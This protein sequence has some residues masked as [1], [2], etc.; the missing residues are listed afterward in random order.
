M[1][2]LPWAC[3]WQLSLGV[4]G[5]SDGNYFTLPQRSSGA[6][7]EVAGKEKWLSDCVTRLKSLQARCVCIFC[8][9][10]GGS[11]RKKSWNSLCQTEGVC[12][13][14][15]GALAPGLLWW[16]HVLLWLQGRVSVC[17]CQLSWTLLQPPWVIRAISWGRRHREST[18]NCGLGTGYTGFGVWT[19]VLVSELIAV[20]GSQKS[21]KS[22]CIKLSRN[23]QQFA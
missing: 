22:F 19:N 1:L 13:S 6:G 14:L 17:H 5:M 7:V 18:K 21:A 3:C 12:V 8:W 11:G 10:E 2:G 23:F 16:L 20:P 4:Q 9:S 15:C